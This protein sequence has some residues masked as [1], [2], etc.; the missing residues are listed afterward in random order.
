MSKFSTFRA[1]HMNNIMPLRLP[2]AWD[3]ASARL[4]ESLGAHAIAT[5]SA[6]LAWSL[7]Y[8]DGR[9]L[10]VKE[11]VSAISRIAR[12]VRVPLSVDVENGYS[13]EPK[14]VAEHVRQMLDLG[15]VG[16]NIE[17]GPDAPALLAA[18]IEAIRTMASKANTELF[19][20]A[21]CDV[22]LAKLVE[23]PK[24]VAESVA[25]ERLYRAAGADGLFLPG[26]YRAHDIRS[27]IDAIALPLNVMAWPGLPD[28]A[29][30][31]RLRV[32]RLSA[33]AGIAHVLWGHAAALARDF[34]QEGRSEPLH[35]AVP[36]A[37]LQELLTAR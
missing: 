19:I 2:N 25:R 16:I 32:R 9:Q 23:E 35:D 34:L 20:N 14:A 8:R 28:A 13:D 31:G 5:T 12:V 22:I 36:S 29:E 26:L 10:P 1:L 30:L 4:F 27:V 33:G 7:G 21:R 18:K 24:Q 37:Q 11:A 17:D 15:V 3:A 6:G